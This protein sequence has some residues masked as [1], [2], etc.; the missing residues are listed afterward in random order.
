MRCRL[1][2]P[3]LLCALARPSEAQSLS[4]RLGGLLFFTSCELPLCLTVNQESQGTHYTFRAALAQTSTLDFFTRAIAATL[5]ATPVSATTSGQTFRFV[6]GAPVST[7]TS[8]GPIFAERAQT[9]GRGRALLGVNTTRIGFDRVRGTSMR[10]VVFNLDHLDLP[11]VGN[12]SR[13]GETEL[14]DP[15]EEYDIMEVHPW[16]RLRLQS[17]TAVVTYGLTDRLDVGVALPLVVA[18]LDAS[19]TATFISLAGPISGVHRFGTE[20]AP[21]NRAASS[22]SGSYTG[23]GDLAVRAKLTLRNTDRLGLALLAD[24]R[25][26]TGSEENFTGTGV[27]AVRGVAVVSGTSGNFSPHVNAGLAYQSRGAGTT[28]ATLTA[29]FDMLAASWATLALDALTDVQLAGDRLELPPPTP[30]LNGLLYPATNV[31]DRRRDDPL[32]LSVGAKLRALGATVV[33]NGLF[34]LK[35]AGV[36]ASRILTLGVERTF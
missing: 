2:A 7:A 16:I 10:D 17:T 32:S 4:D 20:A 25:A 12:V 15:A 29:G 5:G 27:T 14:G 30:F 28:S 34:P 1:A 3:A 19:A 22:A 8:A 9:L 26:P 11:P 24:V 36:Q 6:R 13:V 31:P 18:S 33:V 21:T 35:D 23:L